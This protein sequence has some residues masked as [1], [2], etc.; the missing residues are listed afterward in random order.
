[1]KKVIVFFLMI[2]LTASLAAE[3]EIAGIKV[4]NSISYDGYEYKLK[5]AGIRKK[6]ILKL[7]VGSLYTNRKAEDEEKILKGPVASVIRLDIISGIITSKLMGETVQ[8]GFQ[9]AM[10]GNTA[11]L[12]N[13]ID[14]FIG[15]FKEEINK[16]DQFTFVSLPGVGVTAYKGNEKLTVVLDDR[17]R[18]VLFSIWLGDNPADKKL[19]KKMM[20]G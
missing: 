3:V 20:K 15:V 14:S 16:G 7:Y 1:M 5:G 4:K 17:F 11:S 2:M 9:K 8:E 12:Q 13:E 10:D 19:K 6:L 18:E